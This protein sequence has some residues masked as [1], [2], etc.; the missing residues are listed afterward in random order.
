M[1]VRPARQM[2]IGSALL[3]AVLLAPLTSA[4]QEAMSAEAFARHLAELSAQ[5]S[6]GAPGDV[7]DVRVPA[8]W[9]VESGEQ[10]FDVPAVWLMQAVGEARR[11]P[12]TW[13]K[14]RAGILPRLETLRLEAESLA[15]RQ[16][17]GMGLSAETAEARRALA[18]VL[19]RR[20]FRG[21]AQ[22][23]AFETL[24]QRVFAWFERLLQ[25]LGGG[26]LGRRTTALA[27]AWI[28]TI[29]ALAALAAWT[30]RALR[31]SAPEPR[32]FAVA[33]E[34][35]AASARALARRALAAG[36]PR[37]ATRC[38]YRA[39]V[40]CLEEEGQWSRDATR[41]PREYGRMLPP[42][43]RRHLPFRDVARRF[44]EIWF[45]ARPATDA[46]R[47][48]VLARLRETGCL[49]AE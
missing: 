10:R 37:E 28:T 20:E 15:A 27:L 16:R 18:E 31:R 45:A 33:P 8:V 24:R 12:A 43:H 21:M 47:A 9:T 38:A 14:R 23:S 2:T 29:L 32:H 11:E 7:P 36:D 4:A 5:L 49:P 26:P 44:E 25:R 6:G 35:D 41:T 40:A 1:A 34:R 42:D 17:A 3:A 46:D 22:Q 39:I 30:V 13:P 19:A 48:A